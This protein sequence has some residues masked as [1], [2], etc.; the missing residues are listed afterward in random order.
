MEVKPCCCILTATF[1][2]RRA[3]KIETYTETSRGSS[4]RERGERERERER[5]R[6]RE[7]EGE[8]ISRRMQAQ[9]QRRRPRCG[10]GIIRGRRNKNS[11]DPHVAQRALNR[12][13][14]A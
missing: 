11:R 12:R 4:E 10:R 8:N 2:G 7:R 9:T 3:E 6:E 14:P 1:E 13:I 5:K